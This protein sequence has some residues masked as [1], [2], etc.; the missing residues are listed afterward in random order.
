MFESREKVA[1][2]GVRSG[3]GGTGCLS[4]TKVRNPR[5]KLFVDDLAVEPPY[6]VLAS[7]VR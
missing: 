4:S 3:A 2:L 7:E 6:R 1:L 5:E